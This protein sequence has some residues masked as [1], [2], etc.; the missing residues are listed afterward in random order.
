MTTATLTGPQLEVI[1]L[2]AEGLP[3]TDIATK[4]GG[5]TNDVQ[6]TIWAA[7]RAVGAVDRVNLVAIAYRARLLR[8]PGAAAVARTEAE[9]YH[10]EL[11]RA[12]QAATNARNAQTLAERK[13]ATAR[14]DLAAET[15]RR[16]SAERTLATARTE[17]AAE[18]E[19]RQHLERR[20]AELESAA[21]PTL[22]PA[23]ARV[24]AKAR[25]VVQRAA[26][27]EPESDVDDLPLTERP[28]PKR[29]NN[30]QPLTG[31]SGE[32]RRSTCSVCGNGIYGND[33]TVWGRGRYLG[34]IHTSC[35]TVA[36]A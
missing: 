30:G 22:P 28:R 16:E 3:L 6:D 19:Q 32:K 15:E 36:A 31:P 27:P 35:A 4:T 20:V 23:P 14:N 34:L 5:D 29:P 21:E 2:L 26:K 7:C 8:I 13:L 11:L 18:V 17:L 10:A 9:Q 1:A 33:P 12:Q 24:P 25:K